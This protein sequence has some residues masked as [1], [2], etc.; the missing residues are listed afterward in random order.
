MP[1]EGLLPTE[2]YK[3]NEKIPLAARFDTALR[4][5][6]AGTELVMV[7]F[8]EPDASGHEYGVGSVQMSQAIAVIDHQVGLLMEQIRLRPNVNV[9]FLGNLIQLN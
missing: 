8:H 5:L 9:V 3:Y 2:T 7:Y 4:W 6:D 1:I